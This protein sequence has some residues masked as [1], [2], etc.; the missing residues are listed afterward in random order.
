MKLKETSG[1][2]NTIRSSA[3]RSKNTTNYTVTIFL[4]QPTYK[5]RSKKYL[6]PYIYIYRERERE[7]EREG[8]NDY[9]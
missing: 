1:I 7:I 2:K 6:P 3:L 4:Q 5:H 9:T 8:G